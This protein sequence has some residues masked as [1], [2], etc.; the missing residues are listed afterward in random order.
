MYP[1][2]SSLIHVWTPVGKVGTIVGI[3]ILVLLI[4]AKFKVQRFQRNQQI[5][6]LTK[7]IGEKLLSCMYCHCFVYIYSVE[8][9]LN[10]GWTLVLISTRRKGWLK[11]VDVR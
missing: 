4:C 2:Q 11:M 10:E 6:C 1:F 8:N 5:G 3:L 7:V 9:Y